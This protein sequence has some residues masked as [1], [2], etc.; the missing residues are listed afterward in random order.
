MRVGGQRRVPAGL[1]EFAGITQ[2]SG[3]E[4]G[5]GSKKRLKNFYVD[6]SG[7]SFQPT[8]ISPKIKCLSF[9]PAFAQARSKPCKHKI[10]LLLPS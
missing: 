4:F 8:R 6:G 7:F 3:I 10:A 9:Q 5:L 1:P 2:V